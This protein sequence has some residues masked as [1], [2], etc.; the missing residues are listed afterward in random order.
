MREEC[1]TMDLNSKYLEISKKCSLNGVTDPKKIDV[2]FIET[3]R[4]ENPELSDWQKLEPQYWQSLMCHRRTNPVLKEYFKNKVLSFRPDLLEKVR[5]GVKTVTIRLIR[6][7][8]NTPAPIKSKTMVLCAEDPSLV[9]EIQDVSHK[10]LLKMTEAEILAEGYDSFEKFKTD[11]TEIYGEGIFS[12]D[13]YFHV[14]TFHLAGGEGID[15][16]KWD[17]NRWYW[18]VWDQFGLLEERDCPSDKFSPEQWLDLILDKPIV[19]Q[20][21]SLDVEKRV[22]PLITKETFEHWGSWEICE[23]LFFEGTWLIEYLNLSKIEQEDFDNYWG[24]P[25]SWADAD[26]F[27]EIASGYFPGGFPKHLKLPFEKPEV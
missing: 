4:S 27:F 6:R 10:S 13:N 25:D 20:Y 1:E 21:L 22:Q 7:E 24:D 11:L 8:W 9:L 14:Y 26:E 3:I 16:E 2:E 23:A 5:N 18:E 15:R 19:L 12:A 17:V